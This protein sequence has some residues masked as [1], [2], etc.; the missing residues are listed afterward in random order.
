MSQQTMSPKT[1]TSTV[2][3]E[4]YRRVKL[5]A[6]SGTTV[7]YADQTDSSDYIGVTH[8]AVA[9]TTHVAIHL[10]G[11]QRTFKCESADT[12]AAGADLYAADDGKVSDSASGNVIG[13]ALEASTAAGDI[14]EC[15]LD[16][17]GG[18][19]SWTR[20]TLTQAD[21]AV[22]NVPLTN[23]R[24]WD[25]MHTKAVA[26]TGAND[27]L[28]FV[29]GTFGTS[30]NTLSTGDLKNAGATSRKVGFQFAVPIEYVA[31][32]TITLR[33]NALTA[34]TVASVS[35]TVDCE[36]T[37]YDDATADICATAL[38][39]I[40]AVVAANKDFT[41]TATDVTP[42]DLLDVVLTLA[43]ND[44]G[45]GTAV[46]PTINSVQMLLDIKS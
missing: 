14:V 42:G 13:T 40:N 16:Y 46:N 22:Y 39:S 25:A 10:I 36:V 3:L 5:T 27:D 32:Q 24:V 44:S 29:A 7:E 18:V 35:S 21:L 38:Q 4:A 37:N 6:S 41:I 31:A 2:A 20:A 43:V 34:T 17:N 11:V 19:V 45:T 9:I 1:F 15:T 30:N 12:F 23:M 28:A 26:T 33:V 8:E